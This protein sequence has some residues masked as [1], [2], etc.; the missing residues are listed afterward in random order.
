M[1]RHRKNIPFY[2]WKDHRNYTAL[3]FYMEF[4]WY[5]SE[6]EWRAMGS[7]AVQ[8]WRH[9]VCKLVRVTRMEI[10]L[11]NRKEGNIKVHF[12]SKYSTKGEEWIKQN[13]S[14]LQFVHQ[15]CMG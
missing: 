9:G 2:Q 3:L 14:R 5:R 6:L 15:R 10:S 4:R 1:C 12:K 7:R 8:W 13:V 11:G